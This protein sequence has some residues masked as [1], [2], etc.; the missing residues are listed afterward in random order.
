MDDLIG[1]LSKSSL[2][3]LDNQSLAPAT[4]SDDKSPQKVEL[5]GTIVDSKYK[6]LELLGAGGMGTVY[7]V[8]HL[9]LDKDVALKTFRSSKL[10]DEARL[11]FQREAQAIAKL[12]N[13]N[14]IA[15][16]DFGYVNDTVPYYTMERLI[17]Q[18]LKER[19]DASQHLTAE[20]AV[21]V[22]IQV[23]SGLVAAHKKGIIHRDLKPDNI[24][25]ESNT[26]TVKLVD[27]GIAAL[28]ASSVNSQRLTEMGTVFGSPLYMS[29]EQSMGQPVSESSDIYSCGCALYQA[30]VGK[31]PFLGTSALSTLLLH[32]SAQIPSLKA[33]M[34]GRACPVAL[35]KLVTTMLAKSPNDRYQSAEEVLERLQRIEKRAVSDHQGQS[36]ETGGRTGEQSQV[37]AADELQSQTSGLSAT[38]QNTRE[39]ELQT[40]SQIK[41]MMLSLAA[42][43]AVILVGSLMLY[44]LLNLSN[45][46]DKA[47]KEP[48]PANLTPSRP[49]P[50]V[51]A[52]QS[53]GKFPEVENASESARERELIRRNLASPSFDERLIVRQFTTITPEDMAQIAKTK[54]IRGLCFNRCTFENS[55]LKSLK[56]MRLLRVSFDGSNLDEEGAK[57]LSQCPYLTDIKAQATPLND[58]GLEHLARLKSLVSLH[59]TATRI[60]DGGLAHLTKCQKLKFIDLA[61]VDNIGNTGLLYLS[62]IKSLKELRLNRTKVDFA[63]IAQFCTANKMCTNIGLAECSKL[64]KKDIDALKKRFDKVNFD[65]QKPKLPANEQFE[66]LYEAQPK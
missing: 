39:S 23:C 3:T 15:V 4:E 65:V 55:S 19:L 52:M 46:S 17:G 9:M 48:V 44:S 34:R 22:F 26:T 14:I 8:R 31:P 41:G 58:A 47:N 29:P 37:H 24:F 60:T 51:T 28:T 43:L 66:G 42:V 38:G 1:E 45:F 61:S 2:F 30:L 12:S 40:A 18:S 20:K 63:G 33:E 5:I 50:A 32:Q 54:W 57:W 62:R 64:T 13:R 49:A 11:R 53:L 7:R 21:A 6:V 36:T 25:L 16:Y 56:P 59:L 27:F 10:T 35:E